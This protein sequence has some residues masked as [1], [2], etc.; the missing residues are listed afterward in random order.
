M[1]QPSGYVS[2]TTHAASLAAS[3]SQ[4]QQQQPSASQQQPLQEQHEQQQQQQ[5][6]PYDPLIQPPDEDVTMAEASSLDH[7]LLESLF[8][9]EMAI[10][11]ANSMSESSSEH[12][13]GGGGLGFQGKTL[14]MSN[15]HQDHHHH[16]IAEAVFPPPVPVDAIPPPSTSISNYDHQQSVSFSSYSFTQH[17]TEAVQVHQ[18]QQQQQHVLPSAVND[19]QTHLQQEMNN[20]VEQEMLRDFEMSAASGTTDGGTGS[21]HMSNTSDL[22]AGALN[23]DGSVGF[24]FGSTEAGVFGMAG[25]PTTSVAHHADLEPAV[26]IN[27]TATSSYY[28]TS[29][30]TSHHG[31]HSQQHQPQ[32]SQLLSVT[33]PGQQPS[34][35]APER[36]RTVQ[37]QR[38]ESF[39]AAEVSQTQG[40][41][42][43]RARQLVDQFATLASRLGI[44]LPDNVLQ[45]LTTAAA[46]NY[47]SCSSAASATPQT[48]TSSFH[49]P[50]VSSTMQIPT[51]IPDTKK[52]PPSV[53]FAIANTTTTT[54]DASLIGASEN[55]PP[56]DLLPATI[57]ESQK[58]AEEA[59]AA[60][61]R[62]QQ[63]L[64]L[65]T[66]ITD[67][68]KAAGGV[69]GNTSGS[70]TSP[71]TD[72]VQNNDSAEGKAPTH[73][74]RRKK[75]RL[76]ECEAKLANL[77]AENQ[78][79]KRH[80]EN[81]SNKA[82][83]L[84]KDKVDAVKRIERLMHENAGSD[85]MAAAVHEL[86]DMYS[87]YGANRQQELN[88]HLE[89]LQR[90]VN[91]TNFTKMG[92]WTL[93]QNSHDPKRNPI[94]G[95]LVKELTITSQQGRKILDQSEKI[96]VLCQNLKETHALLAKLKALCE[97]KT[98]IFQDRMS[99]C[100]EILT[101]KQV[102]A[103]ILWINEHTELLESVCPGWG[104]EQIHSK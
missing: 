22:P 24:S 74:K 96:R 31:A 76:Q 104:T 99:K 26:I 39:V 46:K 86:S 16:P 5:Q 52:R 58:V 64:S 12:S 49:Q 97:K 29:N 90:L 62:Q 27:P 38:A 1:N 88:F 23:G 80:L 41:P 94:A 28:A 77:R 91:P 101:S 21:I 70:F 69:T 82:Q 56:V 35:V 6:Q 84:D 44:D 73:S 11:D 4:Q 42:Q 14:L 57:L 47:P 40:V 17:L 100:T 3:I 37:L 20:F 10:L 79:L 36:R 15:Q 98:K 81:V 102:V 89:Q 50:I 65:D 19:Q 66:K 60:A 63:Q 93:G 43:E 51:T 32:P 78:Q 83:K 33:L 18:Q 9:N 72:S 59:I 25:P 7:A 92:L 103:L 95:I 13:S 75:P 53:A 67:D 68:A 61:T 54:T 48:T 55:T 34:P 71:A 30:P 8:Y 85:E 45:S 87:D 2:T